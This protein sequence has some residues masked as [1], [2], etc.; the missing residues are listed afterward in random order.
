MT[1]QEGACL[2]R[3]SAVA[4][5]AACLCFLGCA[6][7]VKVDKEVALG[8]YG[9]AREKLARHGEDNRGNRHYILDKMRLTMACLADGYPDSAEL[10]TN[11][12]FELLRTQ[13]INED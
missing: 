10:A 12:M 5:T 6:S 13:G 11:E 9:A 3:G 2:R 8:D 1:G 4:A 7:A